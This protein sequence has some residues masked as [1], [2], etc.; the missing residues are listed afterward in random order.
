MGYFLTYSGKA[1]KSH[2]W[3]WVGTL[4]LHTDVIDSSETALLKVLS[5]VCATI[6]RQQVTLL[7]LLWHQCGICLCRA[8]HFVALVM[9][10]FGTG[11]WY[12]VE[13]TVVDS[14][15]S[16][17]SVIAGVLQGNTCLLSFRIGLPTVPYFPGH[18]VFRPM[19][20][21]SRLMPS[22]DAKCPICPWNKFAMLVIN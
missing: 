8:R 19:C 11:I 12:Y 6:N 13:Q 1:R 18:P 9:S 16:A 3:S 14:I 7:G 5:D 17:W 4:S 2:S 10:Q 15:I 21:M 20:P 22:R